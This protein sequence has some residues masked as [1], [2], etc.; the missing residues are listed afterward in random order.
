MGYTM[1]EDSKGQL[2]TL[3]IQDGRLKWDEDRPA[4]DA[5][6]YEYVIN[7]QGEREVKTDDQGNPVYKNYDYTNY[8]GAGDGSY[9]M[10]DD[11][12]IELTGKG[13]VNEQDRT[14]YYTSWAWNDMTSTIPYGPLFDEYAITLT[15]TDPETGIETVETHMVSSENGITSLEE[16]PFNRY[17]NRGYD[18]TAV[19]RP[20]VDGFDDDELPVSNSVTIHVPP[21][22]TEA[23][24]R[25]D[26]A[27]GSN[28][29]WENNV[30]EYY[31]T[32]TIHN[33]EDVDLDLPSM[34]GDAYEQ[35]KPYTFT[36]MRDDMDENG[37]AIDKQAVAELV[38]EPIFEQ[39]PE[40][41]SYTVT[42]YIYRMHQD[43]NVVLSGELEYKN[44]SVQLGDLLRIEDNF[45]SGE[46]NGHAVEHVYYLQLEAQHDADY[47]GSGVRQEDWMSS[48]P[49]PVT[50]SKAEF[51]VTPL[52]DV[53]ATQGSSQVRITMD[54]PN[55]NQQTYAQD[56]MVTMV[57]IL[58]DG[59]VI[60]SLP[61]SDGSASIEY[62]DKQGGNLY[63]VRLIRGGQECYS[64]EFQ[65]Y[66]NYGTPKQAAATAGFEIG[67]VESSRWDFG[68]PA[69]GYDNKISLLNTATPLSYAELEGS[70]EFVLYRTAQGDAQSRKAVAVMTLNQAGE[71]LFDYTIIALDD[72]QAEVVGGQ[73]EYVNGNLVLESDGEKGVV[74]HDKFAVTTEKNDH[75]TVYTY[76]IE[77]STVFTD[78]YGNQQDHM[79]SNVVGTTIPKTEFAVTALNTADATDDVRGVEV[80]FTTG[81]INEGATVFNVVC[82]GNV[83]ATVDAA[84]GNMQ[85]NYD[86][87][88]LDGSRIEGD[89]FQEGRVVLA[90]DYRPGENDRFGIEI[91]REGDDET[92][93]TYGTDLKPASQ[94][95]FRISLED[96][97]TWNWDNEENNYRNIITLENSPV[98]SFSASVFENGQPK[99]FELQRQADEEEDVTT[100]VAQLVIMPNGDGSYTYNIHYLEGDTPEGAE[101]VGTLYADGE[102]NLNFYGI[103]FVDVFSVATDGK[104][105]AVYTY[106]L[107]L[108]D[109]YKSFDGEAYGMF[110]N[111]EHVQIH[112]ATYSVSN[113]YTADDIKADDNDQPALEAG[114][115]ASVVI[116]TS[117]NPGEVTGYN[118][119]HNGVVV[120]TV[121]YD[122]S[123]YVWTNANGEEKT[124]APGEKAV[125]GVTADENGEGTYCVTVV[126]NDA[127][128]DTN[129]YGNPK[130]DRKGSTLQVDITK[131][132]NAKG[133]YPGGAGTAG[134]TTKEI[135]THFA[136]DKSVTGT[137]VADGGFNVWRKVT[138]TGEWERL[139]LKW[140][141][142]HNGHDAVNPT[143]DG[144]DWADALENDPAA[145]TQHDAFAWPKGSTDRTVE[146]IVRTYVKDEQ[147]GLYDVVEYTVKLDFTDGTTVTGIDEVSA[148]EM[149]SGD[150]RVFTIDGRQVYAGAGREMQL[151]R[152]TYV[153]TNGRQSL[154]IH[155]K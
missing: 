29:Q 42:G 73:L 41:Y 14:V 152:G 75:P 36:L 27:P 11:Y 142:D 122:G 101:T 121:R 50:V 40:D 144:W 71:S 85:G 56:E 18:V 88:V 78:A 108:Q 127:V 82:N 13:W 124:A 151:G 79:V 16:Q 7:D 31:N 116:E 70:K 55:I 131:I 68:M 130:Q 118:V 155:V 12:F 5:E 153:V 134:A 32:I 21:Y 26:V 10:G 25:L 20:V 87:A 61:V 81:E 9:I 150:V 140:G 113:A 60:A 95:G 8:T 37:E 137:D 97:S 114:G 146:Y 105:P 46:F 90:L 54:N 62:V 139:D 149:L 99:T 141:V 52:L 92:A 111:K 74:F 132:V 119:Y 77:L 43:G 138:E 45:K 126:T 69:N 106:Q 145:V 148:G 1:P 19:V 115:K 53:D 110:S 44:Y 133:S 23:A 147:T 59:E 103:K 4:K 38:L 72:N 117:D 57:E 109:Y 28:W 17:P 98:A 93:N 136:D 83:I 112:Q 86:V 63:A 76:Q 80:V 35:P 96:H 89:G 2:I 128:G 107:Q 6:G 135:Y 66:N 24:F 154:K 84:N 65:G 34:G 64:S 33:V 102:G 15:W 123:N 143:Q 48:K 39:D 3:V 22:Y 51:T 47:Y 104:Q 67:L 120:A 125:V 129:E 30:N 91:V 58:R 49:M 100:A 94:V